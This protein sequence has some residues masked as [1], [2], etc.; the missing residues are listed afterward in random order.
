MDHID[1]C[2]KIKIEEQSIPLLPSL[3][4]AKNE[5]VAANRLVV[6]YIIDCLLYFAQH[7]LALR[8]HKEHW[9]NYIKG[10][11]KDLLCLMG[12]YYLPL[13]AYIEQHKK[14]KNK[15][16]FISWGRQ[17]Q[18]LNCIANYIRHFI[19]NQVKHSKFFSVTVDTTFD[20]SKREQLSCSSIY[21]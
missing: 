15:F 6:E 12:K 19:L 11:F 8:D 14:N 3:M 7:S 17:N 1:A 2:M 9:S 21:K 18:L 5:Q 20:N 10:N 4:K 16:D 13:G